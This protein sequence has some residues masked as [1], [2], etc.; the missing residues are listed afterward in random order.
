MCLCTTLWTSLNEAGNIN[1][2]NNIKRQK[3]TF[4]YT[5]KNLLELE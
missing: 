4:E 5:D 1:H 2:V 3:H